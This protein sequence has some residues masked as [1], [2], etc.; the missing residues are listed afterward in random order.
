M[1]EQPSRSETINRLLFDYTELTAQE[2]VE[3]CGKLDRKILRW[4]GTH[5]PDNRTRKIFFRETHVDIGPEAVLNI[6]LVISDGYL[7]LVKIGARVALSPNVLI[8]A[9]SGPNNSRLRSIDYIKDHLILEA[10][11]VIEDDVWVGASAVVLPGVVIGKMSVVGAGAIVTRT[12][13]PYSIVSGVP[14]RVTRSL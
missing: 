5:H 7:P 4:L 8:I 13:P 1:A 2:I 14:A 12:V 3:E 10:P 9:Q 11:V 6:G